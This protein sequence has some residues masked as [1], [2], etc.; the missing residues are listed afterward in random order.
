MGFKNMNS[1]DRV[2]SLAICCK[3]IV[4]NV[5]VRLFFFLN[6]GAAV[7]VLTERTASTANLDQKSSSALRSLEAIDVLAAETTASSPSWQT[8]TMRLDLTNLTASWKDETQSA[9]SL[10]VYHF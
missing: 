7:S 9:L 1:R 4:Q 6:L 3:P 10:D 8:G 2:A 5:C